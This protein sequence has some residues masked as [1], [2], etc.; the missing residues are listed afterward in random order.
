MSKQFLLTFLLGSLVAVMCSF[1]KETHAIPNPA[2]QNCI[3]KGGTLT[4]LKR[5]DGGQYGVCLFPDGK[6]CE[7]WAL[8]RGDC[9]V[10][11]VAIPDSSTSE[12]SYCLITG[13]IILDDPTQCHLPTEKICP[14]KNFY[15]GIAHRAFYINRYLNKK[16]T[17][18]LER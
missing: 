14:L 18:F 8:F 2:S 3:E 12:E 6:Q 17:N 1:P 15:L 9:P 16:V 4:I 7:E 13:G 11:G 10:G 5:G